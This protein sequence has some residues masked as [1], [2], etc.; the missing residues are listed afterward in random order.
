MP[1]GPAQLEICPA[2]E[3]LCNQWIGHNAIDLSGQGRRAT[4]H[5]R[6]AGSEK[7]Q[8]PVD[9]RLVELSIHLEDEGW[10]PRTVQGLTVRAT[11]DPRPARVELRAGLPLTLRLVD[12]SGRAGGPEGCLLFALAEHE[13]PLIRGPYAREAGLHSIRL[14]GVCIWLGDPGL[15]INRLDVDAAGTATLRGL[16][17]GRYTLRAFGPQDVIFDPPHVEIPQAVDAPV[18]IRWTVAGG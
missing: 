18:E 16:A 15:R 2:L 17:P 8:Q 14:N 13:L 7:P 5:L 11:S 10:M 3:V 4:N 9:R 1:V 12:T 6:H